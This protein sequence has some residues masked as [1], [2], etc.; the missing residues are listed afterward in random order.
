MCLCKC[1]SIKNLITSTHFNYE[2]KGIDPVELSNFARIVFTTNNLLCAKITDQTRRFTINETSD[3]KIGDQ[4]YFKGFSEYMNNVTNQKAIMEYLR[5][6]DISKVNWIK[7]RPMNDT[8]NVIKGLCAE[9]IQKYLYYVWENNQKNNK[10]I[11]R[12]STLLDEYKDYLIVGLKF[13]EDKINFINK[14]TFGLELK[15]L[16]KHASS[17]VTKIRDD[18]GVYYEFNIDILKTHLVSKGL[19]LDFIDYE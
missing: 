4:E 10:V 16:L 5:S 12:A 8:Y 11:K 19:I 3:I 7:D 17:G 9:P 1:E 18:K 6:I 14:T 2:Q 13:K 15:E